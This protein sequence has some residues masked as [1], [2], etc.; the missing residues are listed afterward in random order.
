[1]V[2]AAGLW[3]A[4]AEGD[5]EHRTLP[6]PGGGDGRS[7]DF[8]W[9]LARMLIALA[10]VVAAVYLLL[11]LLRRFFP[12]LAPAAGTAAPIKSLARFHLAPRQALHVVRCGKRLL[13]LGATTTSINHIVTIDNPEEIDQILQAIRRGESPLTGL[14]RFFHRSSQ[15]VAPVPEESPDLSDRIKDQQ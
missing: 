12:A 14:A 5:I 7:V 2:F 15:S 3:A 4:P 9:E 8:G 6:Q 10:V 11:R 1:M 13:V